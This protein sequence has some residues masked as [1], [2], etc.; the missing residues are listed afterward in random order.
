MSFRLNCSRFLLLV[1]CWVPVAAT[2][3]W[4]P[5][6]S[7][8]LTHQTT[9]QAAVARETAISGNLLL[10]RKAETS[11][12]ILHVE[13]ATTPR[14][15]GVSSQLPEANGVVG[16]SLNRSGQGRLQLSELY[17]VATPRPGQVFSVGYLDVSG[18]FEQSRIASDETTQFL[19]SAF[20]SNP[21]IEFPDYTLGAVY[22]YAFEDGP[23]L[24]AGISSSNGLADNPKRSYSQ[25]LSIQTEG[26]GVFAIT[27]LSWR[28]KAWL[29]RLG[30]WV[31]TSDHKAIDS[32]ARGQ[33]NDGSYLLAGYRHER[34]A[35][36]FRY[37]V[38]NESVSRAAS[39]GSLGYQYRAAPYV[40][41]VGVARAALSSREPDPLLGDTQLREIYL[42]YALTPGV[43]LTGDVQHIVNTNF[44]SV[45]A[46]RGQGVTVYG[47][48]LTWLYG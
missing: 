19:G 31:N 34:H 4:V 3:D 7:L 48:R 23:V 11:E 32:S 6:G 20:T 22:E 27:S 26:K 1:V 42:R 37:G 21:T 12:W 16:S 8:V 43:F 5:S 45:A 33:K 18:F 29:L 9:D 14:A 38:A 46:L 35:L 40:L 47:V 24:R 13:G 17:H 41:G 39:F 28:N 2:A 36:N 30:T 15:S 10:R 44:G 25:L